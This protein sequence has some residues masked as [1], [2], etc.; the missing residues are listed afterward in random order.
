MKRLYS[1]LALAIALFIALESPSFS[2]TDGP[3]I[4]QNKASSINANQ[5]ILDRSQNLFSQINFNRI[6]QVYAGEVYS[7]LFPWTVW[8]GWD[9][10]RGTS[11]HSGTARCPSGT[12]AEG[13]SFRRFR[14]ERGN[15]DTYKFSLKCGNGSL[16]ARSQEVGTVEG[17]EVGDPYPNAASHSGEYWAQ[18]VDCRS[19]T[20]QPFTPMV[21]MEVERYRRGRGDHD[22][23][24]FRL[25]C[26]RSGQQSPVMTQWAGTTRGNRVATYIIT[27]FHNRIE[28]LEYQYFRNNSG[29]KDG[30]QFRLKHENL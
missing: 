12:Y 9:A 10:D 19:S 1:L 6:N 27:N 23:Y 8:N 17:S 13:L 28:E 22:T 26:A 15:V 30:Y 3:E 11:R 18:G 14:N 21:G 4:Y 5:D 16:I 29:S 24:R 7:S 2:K 25:A 20:I